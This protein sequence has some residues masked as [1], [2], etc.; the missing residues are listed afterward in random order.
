MIK[1]LLALV[2]LA[3]AAGA[4]YVAYRLS[5]PHSPGPSQVFVD[6]P[7]G[8]STAKIAGML[9][10]AGV[11]KSE[12]VFKAARV[13]NPKAKLKAGEYAFDRPL[14]VLQV[15][16]KI[17]R[18]EIFYYELVIPEGSNMF[19]IANAIE[20]LGLM[21][22]PVFLKVA[23][24]PVMIRDLDPKAPTL[25][26]YLFPA[27][28][29]VTRHTTATQ[30][31]QQMTGQFRK[32]WKEI[33]KPGADV[34]STTTLASLVEKETAAPVERP[35]IAGVYAN[36]LR[37]GMKLDC[38]PTT[39]YAA[40]LEGKY[41]GT[42]YRSNLNSANP[43]NTYQNPG[44]PPGP[45]ANPGMAS[46]QAALEPAP[47]DYLY[48]VAKPGGAGSHNFSRTIAEH[49]HAVQAYRRGTPK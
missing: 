46:L 49:N 37:A 5:T 12:W 30:I 20:E 32:I 28:Y 14:S 7:A 18:G 47:S 31:A 39:I 26:G 29:R 38:D 21:K 36:R 33:E 16:D 40:M 15:F 17:A 13:L 42:I 2:L 11:I 10:S 25:E 4:G 23:A 8:T 44:L 22:A 1:R 24:D 9:A 43:Y 45:I 35:E 27:T 34:H 6:V 19:D 3:L 48:F 41:K